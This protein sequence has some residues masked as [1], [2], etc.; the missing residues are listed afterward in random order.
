MKTIL[1]IKG[2]SCAHCVQHV[3]E[4]LEAVADVISAKVSLEDK[5]AEVEHGD[6]A[7]AA[8]LKAAVTDSG[9]EVV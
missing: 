1:Q 4:A 2:M 3:K 7:S 5:S 6:K 9:Y 8:A